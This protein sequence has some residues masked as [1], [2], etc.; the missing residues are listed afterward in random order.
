MAGDMFARGI[1]AKT[2]VGH[3][4]SVVVVGSRGRSGKGAVAFSERYCARLSPYGAT[5]SNGGG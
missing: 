3:D 5:Q 4:P 1:Q 2:K